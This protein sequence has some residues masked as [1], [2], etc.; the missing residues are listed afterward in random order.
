MK[1]LFLLL[2]IIVGTLNSCNFATQDDLDELNELWEGKFSKYFMEMTNLQNQMN[3]LNNLL[4]VQQQQFSNLQDRVENLQSQIDSLEELAETVQNLQS[5][6]DSLEE[7]QQAQ[8]M[9]IENLVSLLYSLES[10]IINNSNLIND[11]ITKVSAPE[12]NIDNQI[13]NSNQINEIKDDISLL[14]EIGKQQEILIENLVILINQMSNSEGNQEQI[15]TL[16]ER[17][18]ELENEIFSLNTRISELEELL[19]VYCGNPITK[20]INTNNFP[21][22]D[23]V[24]N[25][26][27]NKIYASIPARAENG[28]SIA[29]INPETKEFESYVPVGS[30]PQLLELSKDNKYLWISLGSSRIQRISLDIM[31]IELDFP[32]YFPNSNGNYLVEDMEASPE[33][34]ELLI[35]SIMRSSGSPSFKALV[36]YNKDEI[37]FIN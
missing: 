8:E 33:N 15:D 7:N 14:R 27:N 36:V 2:A 24:Y 5:Q 12:E 17:I 22:N 28:N 9:L 25:K 18:S 32:I 13:D 35:A 11:Y 19:I 23:I 3:G 29:I 31:E 20:I 16:T 1:K 30:E 34:N 37:L 6:I 26:E 4:E 10:E 21:V